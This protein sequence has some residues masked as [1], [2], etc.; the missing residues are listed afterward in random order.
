MAKQAR[1]SAQAD[2]FRSAVPESGNPAAPSLFSNAGIDP[3]FADS[4]FTAFT[5]FSEEQKLLYLDPLLHSLLGYENDLAKSMDPFSFFANPHD[6][7]ALL[8]ELKANHTVRNFETSLKHLNGNIVP[9]SIDIRPIDIGDTTYYLLTLQGVGNYCKQQQQTEARYHL[10]FSSVP[11]GITITD[12]Q[13][14]FYGFNPAFNELLGYS[15]DQIRN[16]TADMVYQNAEDRVRYVSTLERDHIVRNFETN[17]VRADGKEVNVLLNCDLI[18]FSSME[19]IM[20]SSV[21]D[22]TPL[23]SVEAK[24]TKERNFSEAILDTSDSLIAVFG[25]DGRVIKFNKACEKATGYTFD[26][27][28]DTPFWEIFSDNPPETRSRMQRIME[29][30]DLEAFECYWNTKDGRKLLIKW[31]ATVLVDEDGNDYIA[32]SGSDITERRRAHEALR[33]ANRE[34]EE[35]LRRLEEKNQAI[36]LLA[37]MEGLLQGCR[38]V[39]EACTICAQFVQSI[40]P[41]TSGA[42]Y[43]I[44]ETSDLSEAKET[45][46]DESI[47]KALFPPSGCWSVRRGRMNLIDPKHHGLTCPHIR[48]VEN[49]Q[50]LCIPMEANGE[51]LGILHVSFICPLAASEASGKC[52]PYFDQKLRLLTTAA[53]TVALSL[54]NIRLQ[55]TLRQQSIRDMLTGIYNRRYMVESLG[56]ELSRAQREQ[57]SVSVLMFDIDHFKAFNDTYGHDGGDTLLKVLGDFLRQKTR[58]EDIICRYGGEEFVVVLPNTRQQS[59]LQKAEIIR[60]GI[61]RLEV[62]YLHQLMRNCTVS[63]GVASYPQNGQT[64]AELLKAA[65]DALYAAKREGRNRVAS[66]TNE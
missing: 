6:Q 34:L 29:T 17:F 27:I 4:S 50:Y 38:T 26:E 2:S 52:Q 25:K 41:E 18:S 60:E 55:N 7:S 30:R 15:P 37:D 45:W 57:A 5:L 66:C 9:V 21:R 54:S 24:L 3:D 53:E 36:S 47:S 22:I 8:A 11:V 13:G 62:S 10:I 65:D 61:S 49:G 64:A 16:M 48:A 39:G 32:S 1:H 56:R 43:L 46:G 33:T 23:K 12:Q 28:K 14:N 59:A 40:C 19:N 20:L 51:T 58:G 42:I 44:S 31:A 35:S 63:I